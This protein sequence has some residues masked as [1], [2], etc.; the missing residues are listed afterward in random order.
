MRTLATLALQPPL[1]SFDVR[2]A[3][4]VDTETTGLAV[5]MG[6]LVFIIGAAH[7]CRDS[8]V[9]EQWVLASPEDEPAMLHDFGE[10]LAAHDYLV[11]YNGR[12]FDLPLL[13]ARYA[14]NRMSGPADAPSE[15]LDLLPSARR[16]FKGSAPNCRLTTLE[17]AVLGF[18]R[19][20]DMPG[21]EAPRAYADY[22]H[23]GATVGIDGLLA[24]NRDDVLSMVS[25]LDEIMHRAEAPD[26]TWL[27]DPASARAIFEVALRA[28]D[29]ELADRWLDA[30]AIA[31]SEAK[32]E[33]VARARCAR[34]KRRHVRARGELKGSSGA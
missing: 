18:E 4:F 34:R 25:L 7:F 22:L 13:R 17:M 24:H 33:Q 8:L 21:S 19:T 1:G 2:R 12:V 5:S 16:L 14:V 28:H 30:A 29:F 32:W 10:R 27:R 20:D 6:T 31:P 9:L 11:S 26:A 3:L 15:H 23:D